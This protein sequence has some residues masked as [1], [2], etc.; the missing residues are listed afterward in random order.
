MRTEEMPFDEEME[1]RQR[2]FE[3]LE[4]LRK[5]VPDLDEKKEL[6]EYRDEKYGN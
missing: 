2:A 6:A 4:S 5:S 1:E 3:R